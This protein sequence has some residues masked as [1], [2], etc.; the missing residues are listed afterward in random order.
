MVQRQQ[1]KEC[2]HYT[3][4]SAA[5]EYIQCMVQIQIGALVR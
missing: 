4:K 1:G 3:G 2:W 5:R